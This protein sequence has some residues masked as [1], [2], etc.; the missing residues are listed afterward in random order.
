MSA[1]P[2]P[3]GL[4]RSQAAVAVANTKVQG[5]LRTIHPKTS[6]LMKPW[7]NFVVVLMPNHMHKKNC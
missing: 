2:I 6:P 7:L 4:Q 5:A 1:T 3:A